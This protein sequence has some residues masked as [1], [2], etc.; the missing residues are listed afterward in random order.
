VI[1]RMSLALEREGRDARSFLAQYGD[2]FDAAAWP[3]PVKRYLSGELSEAALLKAAGDG[4]QRT[5]A[6]AYVG[7]HLLPGHKDAGIERLREVVREGDPRYFEYDL[8]YHDLRRLGLAQPSD[9][10]ERSPQ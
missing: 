6:L 1:D 4:A 2:R 9:R 7:A 8:A 5:E 10:R 3:A